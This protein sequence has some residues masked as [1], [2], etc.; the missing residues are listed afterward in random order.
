M[1]LL[2]TNCKTIDGNKTNLRNIVIDKGKIIKISNG[3]CETEKRLDAEHNYCIPGCIDVHVHMREPGEEC[4][5]DWLTGS[6]AAAHGGVTTV[7]D[8]PNNKRPVTSKEEL[9]KKSRIASSKSLVN[10]GLYFG[11]SEDNLD[12]LYNVKDLV[13]GYKLYMTS[14][15]ISLDKKRLCERAFKEVAKTSRI[16]VIHAE[17]SI[18]NKRYLAANKHRTD[19][20][21]YADSR[22]NKSE[23]EAIRFCINMAKKYRTKVHITHLSTKEGLKLIKEAKEAGVDITCDTTHTYLFLNRK[24]LEEQ[25]A[26]AKVNPPVRTI[27]DQK[28]LWEGIQTGIIDIIA[29][30]HAPHTIEEK[31]GDFFNAPCG[32]PNLDCFL[33]LLLDKISDKKLSL[34]K[35]VELTAKTPAKRFKIGK[36]GIIKE[37]YDADLVIVDLDKESSI[38]QNDLKTKCRWSPFV[39]RK[40]KGQIITTIVG[41]NLVYHKGVFLHQSKG[42]Q[43]FTNR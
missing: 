30:D 11:I 3:I 15:G 38:Q 16:L 5:E 26:F 43:I 34:Q 10:F 6:M 36:K 32:V 8:M 19:N 4:K 13:C 24:D 37:G 17:N 40:V 22:P 20:L 2:I 27:Y 7:L 18:I 33:P 35:I 41:G 21:C 25:G 9:V 39:G 1:S 28:S 31:S 23:E 12:R 14:S 29:T 42:K